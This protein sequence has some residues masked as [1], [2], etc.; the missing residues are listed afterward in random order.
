M[1]KLVMLGAVVLALAA[2]TMTNPR[3]ENKI[4]ITGV[5]F[6]DAS[7]K[8]G[9]DCSYYI[10]GMF[11]PF[12]NNNVINAAKKGNIKKTSY[13]DYQSAYYILWGED[14]TVVYGK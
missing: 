9:K 14:C 4:D 7:L 12:G 6:T 8:K 11:G 2:C 1:K 3:V 10:L 5:D 13:V